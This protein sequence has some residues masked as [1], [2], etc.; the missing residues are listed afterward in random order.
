[1]P[2]VSLSYSEGQCIPIL[3][4]LHGILVFYEP[5][6]NWYPTLSTLS[7]IRLTYMDWIHWASL[8]LASVGL[9]WWEGLARSPKG[10]GRWDGSS[11]S[12]QPFLPGFR[13]LTCIL[14]EKAKA[15]AG[16]LS[17]TTGLTGIQQ[18]LPPLAIQGQDLVLSLSCYP[19][20]VYHPLL[21]FL[22]HNYS[23]FCTLSVG[24]F[25]LEWWHVHLSTSAKLRTDGTPH[26]G[27]MVILYSVA[28]PHSCSAFADVVPRPPCWTIT[29]WGALLLFSGHVSY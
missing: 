3:C 2:S 28:V 10:A 18:P 13:L 22:N 8:P 5:P 7:L 12:P 15:P 26:L 20:I 4:S 25:L 14:L 23:G 6:K 1:M 21:W 19:G 29:L 27:P 16:A 9:G 11:Y 17:Y 24:C